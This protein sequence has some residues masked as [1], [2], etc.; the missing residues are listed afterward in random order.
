MCRLAW[1]VLLFSAIFTTPLKST[2]AADNNLTLADQGRSDY[3]IVLPEKPTPVEKTAASE[4]QTYLEKATGAKLP[5]VS[6]KQAAGEKKTFL[7][8]ATVE[9]QKLLGDLKLE[10]LDYD[11]ILLKRFGDRILLAG[12]P[13]RG[14][15]YAVYSFL[16][17]QV[18]VRW[19]T[20]NC[21]MVPN[22]PTLSIG[23]LDKVYAPKIRIREAYY[24]DMGNG[25]FAARNKCNGQGNRIT[26]EFGGHQR[27]SL[28]VHTFYPLLPPEKYFKDHPE[29]YSF[30][31][32]KR[33]HK[34]SQLCLS[35]PEMRRELTQ[36]VLKRLRSDPG[37]ALISISQNDWYGRCECEKCKA[38]EEAEGSPAGLLL[39][40]VNEVAREVEKEF[41]DVLVETLAYQYT[42]KPPKTVRPRKNV[43]VRL[44]SIECSFAQNR[45]ESDSEQKIPRRY[46]E[47][48]S[49]DRAA[50]LRLG[51]CDQL[52]PVPDAIPQYAGPGAEP[53][54]F[55]KEPRHR[56]VRARGL[57]EQRGR[58]HPASRLAT[59]PPDV[60][61]VARCR[62]PD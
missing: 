11:G 49:R 33:Q 4:L 53:P 30:R 7:I 43:V 26:P 3:S 28:F 18:G 46:A 8:G 40:C 55:R 58:F 12:H 44:C 29:W 23:K 25:V 1:F 34:Y 32:G 36:N 19:W 50:A 24:R 13:V 10:D 41:P 45:L 37:A 15:L 56:P 6:E 47:V 9:G 54:I 5:I 21:E 51:L 2:A 16:E 14:T 27:F 20:S 22:R 60:G 17:E 39:D 42:R 59:G 31:E 48:E 38:I 52:F 57:S 35:N 62:R 61:L